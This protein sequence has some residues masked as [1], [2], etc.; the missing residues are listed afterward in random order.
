MY[1]LVRTATGVRLA[2]TRQIARSDSTYR[3]GIFQPPAY[4]DGIVYAG[5]GALPDGSCA[6]AVWALRG[7]TGALV[8]KSCTPRSVVSPGAITGGVLFVANTGGVLN[9]Y[10]L[11]T[12][13]ILWHTTIPGEVWG[14]TAVS[15]GYV[16]VG[17]VNGK[18]YCYHLANGA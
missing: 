3:G 2:W 13:T 14:G 11:K 18:L 4:R 17:S 8:W 9:A 7:D 6:G 15:H 12:G 5:S 16:V 1:G 10:S